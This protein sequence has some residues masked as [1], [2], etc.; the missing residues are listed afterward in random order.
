MRTH[1]IDKALKRRN[2][3]VT[4]GRATLG[5][6]FVAFMSFFPMLGAL[7]MTV[8]AVTGGPGSGVLALGPGIAPIGGVKSGLDRVSDQNTDLLVPSISEAL[9]LYEPQLF[10]V[11]QMIDELGIKDTPKNAH[12]HQWV[13]RSRLPRF[14]QLNGAATAGAAGA[15][16]TITVD[17]SNAVV[18]SHL[19]MAHG[20]ASTSAQGQIFLVTG[21]TATTLTLVALTPD[22]SNSRDAAL[23][24]NT[25]GT[26][27]AFADGEYLF[28]VGSAKSEADAASKAIRIKS[29]LQ[30]N[31]IQTMDAV[32][33]ISDH[34]MRTMTFGNIDGWD[35]QQRA[36]AWEFRKTREAAYIFQT[37]KTVSEVVN[38]NGE[39]E[40]VHTMT[41][42][43][44]FVDNEITLSRSGNEASLVSLV[45]D[46]HESDDG[47]PN[48][49]LIG[50]EEF[51]EVADTIIAASN[52]LQTDRSETVAGVKLDMVRGKKGS[53]GLVYHPLFNEYGKSDEGLILDMEHLGKATLQPTQIREGQDKTSGK[54]VDQERKQLIC[55][56]TLI[57]SKATG[58][59]AVHKRISL[60][61]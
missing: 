26:V 55:K 29:E 56:E 53:I 48:K 9:H 23:T 38:L 40:K 58:P 20:N 49:V 34:A 18:P 47:S 35:D 4:A 19:L 28:W 57:V 51:M 3:A 14:V 50:G 12:V 13:E 33:K 6:A 32:A 17:S 1:S 41:G 2:R 21:Q 15:A 52:N 10:P 22:T 39:T 45:Y 43:Y 30:T 54:M 60:V 16:K 25:F 36:L 27:P 44:G 59:R 46:A 42:L 5:F 37:D 61:A 8:S 11:T 31:Y 24:P 7:A